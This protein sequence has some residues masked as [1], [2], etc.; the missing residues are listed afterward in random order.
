PVTHQD[1]CGGLEEAGPLGAGVPG[2][3]LHGRAPGVLANGVFGWAGTAVR[4]RRR[5][6][7]GESGAYARST[8]LTASRWP[9]HWPRRTPAG[10][11]RAGIGAEG[12]GRERGFEICGGRVTARTG[13]RVLGWPAVCRVSSG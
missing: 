5:A 2:G 9:G 10:V 3:A 8:S 11:I 13:P 4:R 1:A 6:P 7:P 12:Y